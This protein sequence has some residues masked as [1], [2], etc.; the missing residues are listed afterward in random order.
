MKPLTLKFI[1]DIKDADYEVVEFNGDLDQ[2]TEE[3]AEPQL[4]EDVKSFKG[5][6]LVY[7]LAGL[8]YINSEGIALMMSMHMKLAVVGKRL[9]LCSVQ[10]NVMD[11]LNLIGLPGLIPFFANM[12]EVISYIKKNS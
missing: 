4:L 2:S 3:Q 11:V 9:L 7:D 5:K 8:N 12:G 1:K 10:P 6:Y